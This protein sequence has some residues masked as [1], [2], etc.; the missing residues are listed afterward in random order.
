MDWVTGESV[1]VIEN[2][3]GTNLLRL[4]SITSR[5][6]LVTTSHYDPLRELRYPL[7]IHVENNDHI[8]IYAKSDD[9][10]V[11]PM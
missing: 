3:Q 9:S 2:N 4:F 8:F 7:F 1:L 10:F 11:G 5:L 6:S